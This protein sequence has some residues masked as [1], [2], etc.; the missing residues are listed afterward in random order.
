MKPLSP[1][2][3]GTNDSRLASVINIAWI[4]SFVNNPGMPE[5]LPNGFLSEEQIKP[6]SHYFANTAYA[7]YGVLVII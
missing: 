3:S 4:A 5:Y 6:K 2:K 7:H 1:N